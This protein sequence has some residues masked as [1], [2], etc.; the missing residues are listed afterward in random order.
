MALRGPRRAFRVIVFSLSLI[1]GAGLASCSGRSTSGPTF[2]RPAAGGSGTDEES[3]G[4]ACLLADCNPIADRAQPLAKPSCPADVP[5]VGDVCLSNGLKCSYGA[6]QASYCREFFVC[7]GGEWV[8]ADELKATC[9]EQ[10][11]AFCPAKPNDGLPCIVGDTDVYVPCEYEAGVL[12]YC[13]G[14][15]PGKPGASGEWACYGPPS[16]KNCP[17]ILP[18]LGDG[19]ANTGL[20]CH[21]G[22]QQQGC[23]SP[24]ADVSCFSGVWEASGATCLL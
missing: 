24:Y 19:C 7:D 9:V 10:P 20:T 12:C 6:S 4:Y 23:Y 22:V 13:F 17:E 5:V 14:N 15:P 1:Q 16:N 18:N 2:E 21:Y 8:L 11:D 3:E